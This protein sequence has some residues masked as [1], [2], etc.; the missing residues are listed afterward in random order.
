[1]ILNIKLIVELFRVEFICLMRDSV[2][3]NWQIKIVFLLAVGSHFT[4]TFVYAP[5][6]LVGVVDDDILKKEIHL[7]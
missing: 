2:Y 7:F 6:M 5:D 3:F 1:M 4:T